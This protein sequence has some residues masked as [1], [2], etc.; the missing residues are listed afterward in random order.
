MPL[1]LSERKTKKLTG[2]NAAPSLTRAEKAPH[3][4]NPNPTGESRGWNPLAPAGQAPTPAGAG[5]K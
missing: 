3:S 4:T 5:K 1:N 2:K